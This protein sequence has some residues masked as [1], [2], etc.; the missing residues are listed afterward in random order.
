MSISGPFSLVQEFDLLINQSFN[1]R[2][3]YSAFHKNRVSC[4]SFCKLVYLSRYPNSQLKA[5]NR[6][7]TTFESEH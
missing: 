6:P 2:L 7:D 1:M 4:S 5:Q 3:W